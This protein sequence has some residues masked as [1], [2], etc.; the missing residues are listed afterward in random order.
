MLLTSLKMPSP[1]GHALGGALLGGLVA[2]A[3][4]S[5]A[6]PWWRDAV[7]FG[8]L[9]LAADLDFLVGQHSQHTHSV[10]AVAVVG[11]IALAARR[12]RA[13]WAL[14]AAAAYASHI[15]LDALGNDTTPPIGVMALW[16]FSDAYYQSDLHVFM[17]ISRRYWLPGFV[18]HNLTAVFWEAVLLA[19]PTVLVWR[20]RRR[21]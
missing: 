6:Q 9:G 2:G 3:P 11:A 8:A 12:G 7:T 20:W 13:R 17:A 19:L 10:A 21:A 14:A 1:I 15:L 5:P 16:P 4:P 18:M